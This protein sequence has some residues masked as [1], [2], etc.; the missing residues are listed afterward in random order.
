MQKNAPSVPRILTMVIFA[1]SCFGL[2]LFLWLSFG[3]PVPLQPE[4][5]RFKAAFPEAATLAEEADVR[6]AGVNVG[7][8]KVKELD[9]G[10][11]RTIAEMEMDERYAP[12]PE[13]TRAI[14]RQ[15]TLLGE[16]YVE[17]TPGDP[18]TGML[19]EGATLRDTNVE[20]T[21]E[22]DEILRIFNPAT[23]N[24]LRQWVSYS[25]EAIEGGTAQDL[26]DALG[27]L[28]E[29]SESG[30]DVLQVLDE[31]QGAVKRL[32]RNTG[33]VFAALNEQDGV[34]RELIINANN[35]FEATASEQDALAETIQI[36]PTFLRES[37]LTLDRL[38]EFSRDTNPLV[39]D[40]LENPPGNARAVVD[41]LGP[42][43]RDL[44]DLSPDLEDVLLD[45][46]PLER[47]SR[48]TLPA[49][50][51]VLSGARPVFRGL[52]TLLPELNPVLSFANFYRGGLADFISV[53]GAALN[54]KLPASSGEPSPI[55]VLPQSALLGANSFDF[56]IQEQ[57]DF[58][59]GNSYNKPG[60]LTDVL[61]AG[62]IPS[63]DCSQTG[64][65]QPQPT[66]PGD[67]EPAP[68]C[69]EQGDYGWPDGGLYPLV[70]G[71][72][73]PLKGGGRVPDPRAFPTPGRGQGAFPR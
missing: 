31:Q 68:P 40:F 63:F 20:Q 60:N 37:R 65:I 55:H 70:R 19:E 18:E 52:H 50:E 47:S 8:V 51:R 59:R 4:G 53:G 7:K 35:T 61:K 29:F 24:A 44:G 33:V 16:T 2:L 43:V 17:L 72:I 46:V 41:E 34:L 25:A 32:I 6:I 56:D 48:D 49:A 14:L 9:K 21:V 27:N 57:R 38:E 54:L 64:G 23:K 58:F 73:K 28:P 36:F 69:V 10:A 5:Y 11:A 71:L 12:I 45:F 67:P 22:L 26:N 3:G 42:T 30:S 39:N 66:P 15:K 1:L 62:A 13:N